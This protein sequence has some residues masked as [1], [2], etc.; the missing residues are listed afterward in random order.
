MERG[1]KDDSPPNGKVKAVLPT[2][3]TGPLIKLDEEPPLTV[4]AAESVNRFVEVDLINPDV[5][6]RACEIIIGFC[7]MS[8]FPPFI[9]MS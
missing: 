1:L 4:Q 7:R 3:L 6:F 9:S 5:S 8:V 2:F